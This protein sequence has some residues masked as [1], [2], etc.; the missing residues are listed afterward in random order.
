MRKNRGVH[1]G[2][3]FAVIVLAGGAG[4]RIGGDGKPLL[5]VAGEAMLG[6]VLSATEHARTRVVVGPSHLGLPPG[7]ALAR[8]QPVGSGPVAALAAGLAAIGP[9]DDMVAREV[10]V[11]ASDLPFLT[12]HALHALRQALVRTGAHVA[13]YRDG[14]GRRQ[15]LCGVWWESALRA[16]L[17]SRVAGAPVRRL[18]QGLHVAELEH[19][20]VEP[21]PWYDCDTPEDLAIARRWAAARSA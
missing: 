21:P 18:F 16:V 5:S 11:L 1:S 14:A 7:V 9:A 2:P 6:R 4:R 19:T 13:V 10:A 12:A 15:L 8:E 20:G 3:E 17:P